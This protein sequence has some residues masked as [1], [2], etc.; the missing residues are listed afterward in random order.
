MARDVLTSLNLRAPLQLNGASGTTGQVLVSQ[1]TSGPAVWQDFNGVSYYYQDTAPTSPNV[2]DEWTNKS[3][4]K[5]PTYRYINDGTS[6]Q[7]VNLYA[8]WVYSGPVS[9]Q[10]SVDFGVQPV[11]SK[12]FQVTS[13]PVAV[14][15]NLTVA[16]SGVDG[17]ELECDMLSCAAFVSATDTIDLYVHSFPGPVTGVRN[18]V[19]FAS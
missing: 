13:I 7:W 14:G 11:D 16:P 18:F 17:D 12:L 4:P 3:D 2:G 15:Q 8:T 10:L 6:S 5:L 1:G 9:Y 19:L